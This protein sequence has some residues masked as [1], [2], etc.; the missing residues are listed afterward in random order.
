M[1]HEL[2]SR[3]VENR[4]LSD[5]YLRDGY[6]R[7]QHDD[8]WPGCSLG[9]SCQIEAGP[10]YDGTAVLS[11]LKIARDDGYIGEFRWAFGI[12]DLIFGLGYSGPAVL[13]LWWMQGMFTPDENG[14]IWPTGARM[15][16]HAICARGV[17]IV[18]LNRT[19]PPTI[20]NIDF[21]KSWIRL[22]NSW[23]RG[24]GKDGDCFITLKSM[25]TLLRDQGE[26]AL[27]TERFKVVR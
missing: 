13:G 2:A 23:G 20:D 19:Q 11:G 6:H 16:G 22:R 17:R 5:A 15:G 27:I 9:Q 1:G 14:F 25:D 3:P 18:R 7:A 26:A 24:W 21:D 12:E 8:S 4:G 10:Q